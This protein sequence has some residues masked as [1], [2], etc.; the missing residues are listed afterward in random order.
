MMYDFC[1][2]AC[3]EA[4]LGIAK[5]IC[6]ELGI[7]I[8]KIDGPRPL[9]EIIFGLKADEASYYLMT[10]EAKVE[11]E[12]AGYSLEETFWETWINRST[13]SYGLVVMNS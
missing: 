2:Y 6:N 4:D 8:D 11:N 5:D 7:E 1:S 3:P 12:D 10:F 13:N 9:Y